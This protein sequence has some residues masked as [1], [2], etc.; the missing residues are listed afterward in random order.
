M[1]RCY[2][3]VKSSTTSNSHHDGD[4]TEPNEGKNRMSVVFVSNHFRA[5]IFYSSEQLKLND[6]WT[7]IAFRC[8]TTVLLLK[9]MR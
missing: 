9:R 8:F 7:K 2:E 4:D 6:E 5:D 3:I 1:S